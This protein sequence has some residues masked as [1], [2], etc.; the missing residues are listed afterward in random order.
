MTL[1][2]FA[3]ATGIGIVPGTVVYVSLARGFDTVLA[4]GEVPDLATLSQLSVIGPLI[5]LGVLALI[6]PIWRQIQARKQDTS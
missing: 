5:A 6:P 1:G 3:L 2:S 4:R